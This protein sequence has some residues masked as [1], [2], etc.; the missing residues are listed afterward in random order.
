MPRADGL[1]QVLLE[2]LTSGANGCQTV[3]Q[4][5]SESRLRLSRGWG[6]F[7]LH[8][9]PFGRQLFVSFTSE[10]QLPVVGW[11][12]PDRILHTQ[13]QKKKKIEF[14]ILC[15]PSAR[16]LRDI[17]KTWIS[18]PSPRIKNLAKLSS[19][20]AKNHIRYANKLKN[21]AIFVCELIELRLERGGAKR[22]VSDRTEQVCFWLYLF[23]AN[24]TD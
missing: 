21:F 17:H 5:S 8:K 18:P 1:I 16:V 2:L 9:L 11:A 19:Q 3:A 13:F 22:G 15:H 20:V 23:G 4:R 24:E 7:D 10:L 6:L 12:W 14:H